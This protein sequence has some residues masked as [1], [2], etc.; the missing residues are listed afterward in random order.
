MKKKMLLAS[1]FNMTTGFSYHKEVLNKC[2]AFL[3]LF[4]ETY[5]FY[6]LDFELFHDSEVMNNYNA[7]FVKS[8]IQSFVK[9][10]EKIIPIKQIVK[11]SIYDAYNKI[12]DNKN[13][14]NIP[15]LNIPIKEK[16]DVIFTFNNYV[17]PAFNRIACNKR[18]RYKDI[19]FLS[20]YKDPKFFDYILFRYSAFLLLNEAFNKFDAVKMNL[21][22]DPL[23]L[24]FEGFTYLLPDIPASAELD[25]VKYEYFPFYQYYYFIHKKPI[26]RKKE[27]LLITGCTLYDKWRQGLFEK[28]LSNIYLREEGNPDYKWYL[29]G[30]LFGKPHNSFIEPDQFSE[31][32]EKSKFGV[33][34]NTYAKDIIST[35]KSSNYISRNCVPVIC[36]G[37][38]DKSNFFP[39]K[40][41]RQLQ[42]TSGDDLLRLLSKSNYKELN[43]AVQNE[44][45]YYRDLNYYRN[46]YSKYF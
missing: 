14:E 43:E 13:I 32:I 38:D 37:A 30:N 23:D 2:T 24:R 46:V 15:A 5:D 3:N 27:Y 12:R 1:I 8:E 26:I 31:E 6:A 10:L 44:F 25:N 39:E 22:A 11:L 42:I 40:L 4:K 7:T 20:V 18:L 19:Q 33:V 36:E 41:L 34:L 28:Y 9:E 21:I 29:T 17:D 45:A 16:I 35:N